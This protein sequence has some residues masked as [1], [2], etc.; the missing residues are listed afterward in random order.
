MDTVEKKKLSCPCWELNPNHPACSQLLYC[1]VVVTAVVAVVVV[2]VAAAV[3]VVMVVVVA[4][5]VVGFMFSFKTIH[6]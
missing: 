4:V 5:V 3:V 6:C 2:V 1:L